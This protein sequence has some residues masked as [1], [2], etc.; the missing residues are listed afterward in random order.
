MGNNTFKS[1]I[2]AASMI[3]AWS[4]AEWTSN[5]VE[6]T[7]LA[8]QELIGSLDAS[9]YG[10]ARGVLGWDEALLADGEISPQDAETIQLHANKL[11][12]I[13]P[14][15]AKAILDALSGNGAANNG[16]QDGVQA[17]VGAVLVPV[18][19]KIPLNE[20]KEQKAQ[21]LA[22]EKQNKFKQERVDEFNKD[23]MQKDGWSFNPINSGD[24]V[25]K[26]EKQGISIEFKERDKKN[27]TQSSFTAKGRQLVEGEYNLT[28][29]AKGLNMTAI[30]K[31][32]AEKVIG[33]QTIE[34]GDQKL[35]VPPGS[36]QV[37]FANANTPLL[38]KTYI[39][40][41]VLS[42][43]KEGVVVADGKK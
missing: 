40:N 26:K 20:T 11:L 25:I 14:D 1:L 27:P 39:I 30:F 15:K 41:M 32:T 19:K 43:V 36:M 21:R 8:I 6:D 33:R 28:V 10:A 42:V 3:T 22:A 37:L 17:Q 38:P 24:S 5:K 35:V 16:G 18:V 31:G 9:T 34:T 4:H 29:E 7:K 2:V 12:W 13:A 23:F